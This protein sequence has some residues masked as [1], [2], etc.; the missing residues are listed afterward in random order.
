M[1]EYRLRPRA[2]APR[3]GDGANEKRARQAGPSVECVAVELRGDHNAVAVSDDLRSW[4]RS[5][6]HSRPDN[7]R[8][9]SARSDPSRRYHQNLERIAGVFRICRRFDAL[10]RIRTSDPRIRSPRSIYENAG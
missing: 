2:L 9:A 8:P 6:A 3:R 7:P 4:A 5:T 10:G 1:D